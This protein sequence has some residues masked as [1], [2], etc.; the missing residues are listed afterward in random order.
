VS[1]PYSTFKKTVLDK[2][3]AAHRLLREF[4]KFLFQDEKVSR[5]IEEKTHY[6]GNLAQLPNEYASVRNVIEDYLDGSFTAT[7]ALLKRCFHLKALMSGYFRGD[8][9][10][11][12]P[13]P[14][15]DHLESEPSPKSSGEGYQAEISLINIAGRMASAGLVET[16]L[17]GSNYVHHFHL[18]KIDDEWRIVSKIY[19]DS[20]VD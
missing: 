16:N 7:A 15:Y 20:P 3:L 17:L 6:W 11:D 5:M 9:D 12:S 18:L 19:V 8:L 10:I 1:L 14:F 4:L 2:I 13:Q